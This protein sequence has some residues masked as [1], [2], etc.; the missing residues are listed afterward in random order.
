MEVCGE[1]VPI[2]EKTMGLVGNIIKTTFNHQF[3][4]LMF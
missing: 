4:I 3:Y 1:A 2:M